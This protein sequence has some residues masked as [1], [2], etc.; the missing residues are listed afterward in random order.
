MQTYYFGKT[1]EIT[2]EEWRDGMPNS[3]IMTSNWY[4]SWEPKMDMPMHYLDDQI[5]TK[6][7]KTT[8][9]WSSYHQSSLQKH[10]PDWQDQKKQTLQTHTNGDE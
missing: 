2:P 9:N 10:T 1:P 4:T 3:W 8:N 5:M 7:E 6:V